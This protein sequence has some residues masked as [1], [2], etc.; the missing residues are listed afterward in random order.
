[1]V[2]IIVED[3][4]LMISCNEFQKL[5]YDDNKKDITTVDNITK[6]RLSYDKFVKILWSSWYFFK[7]GPLMLL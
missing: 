6:L 3:H 7:K 5:T 4:N 2:A 1:L